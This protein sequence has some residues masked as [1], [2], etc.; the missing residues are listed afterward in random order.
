MVEIA[1]WMTELN[2][3]LAAAE[4]AVEKADATAQTGGAPGVGRLLKGPPKQPP[5]LDS[6]TIIRRMRVSYPALRAASID[7][8]LRALLASELLTQIFNEG[9][10]LVVP[11]GLKIQ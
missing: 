2:Q 1:P 3:L 8:A 7:G 10:S 11:A 4:S 9:G 6:A 5:V